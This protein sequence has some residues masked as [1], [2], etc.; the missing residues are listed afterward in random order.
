[1]K[2]FVLVMLATLS[3]GKNMTLYSCYALYAI[4]ARLHIFVQLPATLT[5]LCHIKR[6]HPVYTIRLKCPPSAEMHAAWNGGCAAGG[7]GA[8]ERFFPADC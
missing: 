2:L 8:H 3:P 6:D 4:W 7:D 1:M 5:K